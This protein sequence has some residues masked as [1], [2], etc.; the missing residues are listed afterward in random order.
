MSL[1]SKVVGI[2]E[3]LIAVMA[4]GFVIELIVRF[5][6]PDNVSWE[7]GLFLVPAYLA[8]AISFGWAGYLLA[9]QRANAWSYQLMPLVAMLA[10]FAYLVWVDGA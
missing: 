5:S 3:I 4:A 1:L 6:P 8:V 10:S 7:A 2:V 9:R